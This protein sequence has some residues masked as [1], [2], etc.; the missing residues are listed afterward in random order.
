MDELKGIVLYDIERDGC[1]N[2]VYTNNLT[3]NAEIYT[4]TAKRKSRV[5]NK[6]TIVEVYDCFYFDAE[7]ERVN[8]TLTFEIINGIINA[9]WRLLNNDI[10]FT[11][12]GFLMN[13]RQIAISYWLPNTN[14]N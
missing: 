14:Q 5:D 4:E 7:S 6:N 13:D 9:E 10:I 2:G 12:Q 3:P 8:C 11:G 1:L